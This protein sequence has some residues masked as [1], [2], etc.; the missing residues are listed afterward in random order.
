MSLNETTINQRL[1]VQMK[2]LGRKFTAHLDWRETFQNIAIQ[3]MM[4]QH[5]TTQ[6]SNV[7]CAK[8]QK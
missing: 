8:D 3:Q 2:W 4:E 7:K 1:Q 5:K 6:C